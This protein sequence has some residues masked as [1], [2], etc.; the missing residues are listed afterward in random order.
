MPGGRRA[1]RLRVASTKHRRPL[2]GSGE[3]FLVRITGNRTGAGFYA[4]VVVQRPTQPINP[5]VTPTS[6][7]DGLDG[8][9]TIVIFNKGAELGSGHALTDTTDGAVTQTDFPAQWWGMSD[10]E[11]PQR[12]AVIV[13]SNPYEC[14][15]A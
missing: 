13:G 5:D 8:T 10:D 9:E 3:P 14:A 15:E 7:A 6:D 4:G 2:L 11:P 12:V 1:E